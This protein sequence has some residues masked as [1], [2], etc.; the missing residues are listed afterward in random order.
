MKIENAPFSIVDWNQAVPVEYKGRT[1]TSY[2]RTLEAGNV[3]LRMVEYSAGFGTD[4][5]CS[6]GHVLLVLEGELQ[7]ELRDGRKLALGPGL[8]F[9]VSD[10]EQNPHFVS[11]EV[12]TRVFIVD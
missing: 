11:T 1:G 8:S 4:H 5:W 2:W 7:V 9:C 6:R 12:P 10:D 3:R